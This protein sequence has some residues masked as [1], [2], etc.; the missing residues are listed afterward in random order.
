L[1]D[2]R[3]LSLGDL[4]GFDVHPILSNTLH[5]KCTSMRRVLNLEKHIGICGDISGLSLPYPEK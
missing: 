5:Q 3:G 2:L 4:R 1:G